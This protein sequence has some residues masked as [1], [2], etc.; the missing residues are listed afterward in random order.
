LFCFRPRGFHS[1][2]GSDKTGVRKGAPP[3]TALRL[4][5]GSVRCPQYDR[6]FDS[7]V[8]KRGCFCEKNAGGL[9]RAPCGAGKQKKAARIAP[10]RIFLVPRQKIR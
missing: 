5:S 1:W 7:G 9:F 10:D 4:L 8:K 6:N 2:I 3:R